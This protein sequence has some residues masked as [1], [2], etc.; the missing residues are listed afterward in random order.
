MNMS[1]VEKGE[2]FKI[3]RERERITGR[4]ERKGINREMELHRK[5]KAQV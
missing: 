3:K 2:K 1:R 4:K 5:G